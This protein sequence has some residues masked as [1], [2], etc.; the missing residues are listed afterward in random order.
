M[1]LLR[2]TL[3]LL[4]FNCCDLEIIPDEEVPGTIS[5]LNCSG[6]TTVGALFVNQTTNNVLVSVPY[7]GGDGGTYAGESVTSTGVTGLTATLSDGFFANGNGTLVYHITGTPAESGIA[8]FALSAGGKSCSVTVTVGVPSGSIGTLDCASATISGTLLSGVAVTNITVTVPYTGGNG[9]THPGQT[10]TSSTPGVS[11]LT[12][13]LDSGNFASGNGTLI[14]SISGTPSASG[15]AIFTLNIGGKM[16]SITFSV[17]AA[18]GAIGTLDCPDANLTGN[19]ITCTPASGV[20]ISVPYTGGN[21]G[22]HNGQIVSSTGVAGLTATLFAANFANGNGNLTYGITGTPSTT[23]V[24]SFALNIGGKTCK[25]DI[26][27]QAATGSI[28]TIH[29]NTATPTGSLTVGMP[30]S[31]V[32]VSVPYTGGNGGSHSG[33]TI[34][35]TGVLGLKATLSADCFASGSGNLIYSISG[36][37]YFSGI[38]SF[39]LNIGGQSCSLQLV[40]NVSSGS[41]CTAKVTVTEIKTFMCHNLEVA[42]TTA[43]PFTPSWEINGAYWQWGR[44]A[45]A[46]LGPTGSDS[47]QANDGFISGWNTSKAPNGAWSDNSKMVNDPCPAGF[48]VPSKAQWEGVIS[49]N[50]KSQ[51]GTW[52]VSTTNY[53]SGKI[54][55]SNLFLPAAGFRYDDSGGL[56]G[57][58]YSG[59]YWSSTEIGSGNAWYLEFLNNTASIGNYFRTSGVSVRCISE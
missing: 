8:S 23:G 6:I 43:D 21:G 26:N 46:A 25:L 5:T 31:G 53:S 39:A 57:R 28:S 9:G 49:F 4:F 12:A 55:G 37:P 44:L 32:S 42:N 36:T 20:S 22:S 24:A 40:V 50:T 47:G 30:A 18:A 3:F 51:V 13:T 59:I 33:Q 27:V 54:F 15:T 56:Y 58:G 17:Q 19:L 29:C 10:V 34:T 7:T 45:P 41:Q 11:G 1:R 14:Y 16:C 35:S 2:F 52:T 48:R 38:A